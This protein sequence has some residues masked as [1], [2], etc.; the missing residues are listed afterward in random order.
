M[1]AAANAKQQLLE[2]ASKVL[3][4]DASSLYTAGSRV[5]VTGSGQ[6][7]SFAEVLSGDSNAGG[8]SGSGEYVHSSAT[9]KSG[10]QFGAC[11][12]EVGVDT[13]TGKVATS[14][15]FMVQDYGRVINPL[16][17]EGQMLGAAMQ[18]LAYGLLEDYVIDATTSQS[19]TRDWLYYRVP[20]I[21]DVPDMVAMTL[22]NPDPRGPVGR[23]RRR[24]RA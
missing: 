10:F 20:T 6:S 16:A 4:A 11:F 3:K 22:E 8:I 1:S 23:Q 17:A 15:L 14:N 13:W 7:A 5:F 9:S 18:G 21:A 12:A 19:I 24:R 2:M